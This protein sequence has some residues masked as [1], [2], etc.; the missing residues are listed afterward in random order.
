M[1]VTEIITHH[2]GLALLGQAPT[3]DSRLQ[4]RVLSRATA[5]R[6]RSDT[7]S[8]EDRQAVNAGS[9][10][11]MNRSST[12]QTTGTDTTSSSRKQVVGCTKSSPAGPVSVQNQVTTDTDPNRSSENWTWD[13]QTKVSAG[14]PTSGMGPTTR[15]ES[16]PAGPFPSDGSVSMDNLHSP[17]TAKNWTIAV[18]S[19]CLPME[20]IW[21]ISCC[22]LCLEKLTPSENWTPI[23]TDWDTNATKWMGW[24]LQ[25]FS[26][27]GPLTSAGLARRCLFPRTIATQQGLMADPTKVQ[28]TLT[29]VPDQSQ[30]PHPTS[31]TCV[32]GGPSASVMSVKRSTAVPCTPVYTMS[33]LQIPV[34]TAVPSTS[35]NLHQGSAQPLGFPSS[36]VTGTGDDIN[37]QFLDN[38]CMVQPPQYVDLNQQAFGPVPVWNPIPAAAVG[39]QAQDAI[40][41]ASAMWRMMSSVWQQ[42]RPAFRA[43][44][45]VIPQTPGTP[46]D[47]WDTLVLLPLPQGFL[48]L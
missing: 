1:R 33:A 13:E 31:E 3:R 34:C 48:R 23:S 30:G 24:D 14:T 2:P 37:H 27:P 6:K 16:G 43:F 25:Q 35:G 22:W 5:K 17:A 40:N 8:C 15:Q 42:Q 29:L 32:D 9:D 19:S 38:Y 4:A 10:G 45:P 21:T 18:T 47:I 36:F 26:M 7:E 11:A 41:M 12:N 46:V 39:V 20:T 28:H 44:P